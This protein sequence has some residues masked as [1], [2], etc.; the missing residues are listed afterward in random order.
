MTLTVSFNALRE[1]N[2][3][4]L[5]LFKDAKGR[6]A[7]SEA[8]GSDWSVA[9]WMTAVVGELG[10]LA[11]VMKKVK[12]GDYTLDDIDPKG[13]GTKTV[14]QTMSDEFA[15]VVIYL[16]LMA[17]QYRLNLGMA[18]ADKFNEVSRRVGCNVNMMLSY[19]PGK[20]ICVPAYRIAATRPSD[21]PMMEKHD[22]GEYVKVE[23]LK[24]AGYKV[25]TDDMPF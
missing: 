14:R 17:Y 2:V 16:D 6:T 22:D 24:S 4:R 5:P 1:A 12:R 9:D 25:E 20:M 3:E 8:D 18:V 13:D 23:D 21:T 19:E 7:H 10:E 15:D 11:N